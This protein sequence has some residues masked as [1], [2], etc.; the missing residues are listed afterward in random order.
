[1]SDVLLE[2]MSY[3]TSGDVRDVPP[4]LA[5]IAR[6]YRVLDDLS[7]LGHV[8][9]TDRTSWRVAPPVL[10]GMP[11]DCGGPSTAVLCGARTF[12]ILSRLDHGCH[13]TGTEKIT[14]AVANRPS[15]IRLTAPSPAAMM[16]TA[17]QAGLPLQRDASLT[18]L[19][20]LPAI[21]DWPRTACAMVAGRVETVRRFSRS[22]LKWVESSLAEATDASRGLF[23]IRRDWDS[24]TILKSARTECARIDDR[25]GRLI[26]AA[27]GRHVRWDAKAG[28][29]SFPLELYP[30]AIIARALSLC[31]GALPAY[32]ARDRVVR[33]SGVTPVILRLALAITGLRLA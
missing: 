16:A 5:E 20:C 23:R 17:A 32:S 19:A 7:M 6:I 28:V 9:K 8:E 4:E 25:A 12:G 3:R 15:V 18:L 21:S 31:A 13:E 33:F 2:W 11:G 26:V 1:M 30:P 14:I 24:V 22:R 10:A 29:M 27:K